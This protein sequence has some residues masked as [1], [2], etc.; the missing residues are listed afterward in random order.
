M[1]K[2]NAL[3]NWD[4]PKELP[5][6]LGLRLIVFRWEIEKIGIRPESPVPIPKL[7]CA[8]DFVRKFLG[9]RFGGD[10]PGLGIQVPPRHI[11]EFLQIEV[12]E[13]FCFLPP[14][15]HFLRII[16]FALRNDGTEGPPGLLDRGAAP[17]GDQEVAIRPRV[18]PQAHMGCFARMLESLFVHTVKEDYPALQSAILIAEDPEVPDSLSCKNDMPGNSKEGTAVTEGH[19]LEV[20]A[21]MPPFVN[22]AAPDREAE[23]RIQ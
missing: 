7:I 12:A 17:A 20:R 6:S 4:D 16:P 11:G 2:K 13:G 22:R 14:L 1:A 19:F 21:S 18:D 23:S 10:S 3:T 8:K 5:R 9:W 15:K